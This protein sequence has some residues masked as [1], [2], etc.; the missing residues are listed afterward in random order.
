MLAGDDNK[1][2]FKS[3]YLEGLNK[4]GI[5]MTDI[6]DIICVMSASR[7]PSLEQTYE[8]TEAIEDDYAIFV[9]QL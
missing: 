5:N 2:S 9:L 1:D 3:N 7:P 4:V 8:V 6:K